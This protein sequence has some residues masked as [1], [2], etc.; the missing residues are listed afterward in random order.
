[1]SA[2]KK[3]APGDCLIDIDEAA[4]RQVVEGRGG[5]ACHLAPPCAACTHEPTEDE[6]NDVG[7]TYGAQGGEG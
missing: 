7:L 4:W 1:M 2:L 6:L 5:C 3:I